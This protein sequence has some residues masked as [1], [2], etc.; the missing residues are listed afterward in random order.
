M[1][2]GGAISLAGGKRQV[3][4]GRTR[5]EAA[6]KLA[7]AMKDAREGRPKPNLRQTT[8]RYLTSW[9]E[10]SAKPTLRPRTYIGYEIIVRQHIVPEIGKIPLAKLNGQ[11]VQS[12]QNK[13]LSRGLNPHTVLN[14]RRVLG[15]ALQQ[16]TRWGLIARNP[17][18]LVDAPRATDT[19]R[20]PLTPEQASDLLA[21]VQ[22]DRLSALYTVGIALG[23]RLGEAL[24]LGW[25]DV[26]LERGTLRVR[27]ALQRHGGKLQFV[28]PKT[29][30]SHRTLDLPGV[31]VDALRAHKE[32]QTFERRA[33]R[34]LWHESGLVFTST[35]GT[36]LEPRN[37]LRALQGHVRKAGLP[38]QRFHDLRHA[39]ASFLLAQGVEL[40]VV[41][42][43]LGHSQISTTADI[44]AHVM[45]S[46]RRQAADRMDALLRQSVV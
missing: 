31:V 26:D 20:L 39:C 3:V 11:H 15:R 33:V 45:P 18:R 41:Q 22:T 13:L 44:Y 21:T 37:G 5:K 6:D 38:H 46:L 40:K 10:D 17:V 2:S 28:E 24:A 30:K 1:A 29:R 35:I 12:L 43:T 27:R 25:D 9:L 19:E 23:L 16:A 4:Y 7:D 8:D 14:V 32:R 36:P 42:E 34:E